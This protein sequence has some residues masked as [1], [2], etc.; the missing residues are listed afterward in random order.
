V[1]GSNIACPSDARLKKNI[2]TLTDALAQL[3]QLR[4]VRYEWR[5]DIESDREFSK[6]EQIGLIAQEVQ[7]VVPQAVVQMG[8]GYY[9]VDY[10]R[11]VPLLIQGMKEQQNQIAEL[12][13]KLQSMEQTA[14]KAP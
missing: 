7:Q 2:E 9:S 12:Q 3:E 13:R 6:G 8:D 1:I 5:D 10:S 14:Q 11:L 4:G